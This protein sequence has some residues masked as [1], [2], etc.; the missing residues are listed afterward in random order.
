MNIQI[1][2]E[3]DEQSIG[4]ERIHFVF[5]DSPKTGYAK[6]TVPEITGG[7]YIKKG[8]VVPNSITIILREETLKEKEDNKA[9][10]TAAIKEKRNKKTS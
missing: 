4:E 9:K 5:P 6:A 8:A 10:I 1:K 7:I 2:A 3:R